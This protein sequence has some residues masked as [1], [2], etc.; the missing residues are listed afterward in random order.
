MDHYLETRKGNLLTGEKLRTENVGKGGWLSKTHGRLGG[1]K[2]ISRRLHNFSKGNMVQKEKKWL[3][4]SLWLKSRSGH[5]G[6]EGF[7]RSLFAFKQIAPGPTKSV[8]A[9]RWLHKC[10]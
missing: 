6:G 3:K 8:G 10:R 1:L 5:Q 9:G 2:V 7:A 4:E